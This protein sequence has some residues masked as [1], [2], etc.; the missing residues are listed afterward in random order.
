MKKKRKLKKDRKRSWQIFQIH[1]L[2]YEPELTVRLTRT[3]HFFCGR[4]EAYAKAHGLTPGFSGAMSYY[5][6]KYGI[7]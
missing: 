2:E 4:I 1:H 7:S 5:Y 6:E 3:E